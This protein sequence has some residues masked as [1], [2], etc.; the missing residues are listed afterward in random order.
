MMLSLKLTV[1]ASDK[2]NTC[3]AFGEKIGTKDRTQWRKN[4]MIYFWCFLTN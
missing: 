2:G 1:V 3:I 4:K